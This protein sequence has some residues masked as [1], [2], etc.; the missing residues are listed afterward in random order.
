MDPT[1]TALTAQKKNPQRV[2]VFLDGEFSFG[3]QRIVAAWLVVG[4]TLS[5]EKI[6]QLKKDD[7]QEIAYQKALN[8]L[9]YR[10]HSEAEIIKK[11]QKHDI[12]NEHIENA[13]ERLKRSGLLDDAKFTEAW[14]A[15]RNEMRPRG[16]RALAY[17]LKQR[18]VN[19]ETIEAALEDVN[20][21]E[22]AYQAALKRAP[23]LKD[24]DWGD[25]RLKLTR[26]LAQRGF[27]YDV[28][29]TVVSRLW[30]ENHQIEK[31]TDEGV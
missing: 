1:I 2:N 14:I 8:L 27:N 10:L 20:E 29:S 5:Q 6:A 22:M 9:S 15:N 17:E 26:F 24:M 4:Q 31:I 19:S 16:R 30:E 23:R 11:L 13:L 28:I 7:Q 18:G 12:A 3:L 25:F 21:E